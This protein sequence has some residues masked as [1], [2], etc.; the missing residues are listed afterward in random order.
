M[1]IRTFLLSLI[2]AMVTTAGF[3][4]KSNEGAYSCTAESSGGI[5]Y[6][7]QTKKWEGTRFRPLSKFVLRFN[8]VRTTAL[9]DEYAVSVSPEGK[10][11]PQSCTS[12]R[13]QFALFT[14]PGLLACRTEFYSYRFNLKSG[15]FV[16]A[17]MMGY[18]NDDDT[19]DDTPVVSGGRCTKMNE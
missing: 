10:N 5:F 1:L 8:Y 16:E 3:A 7:D 13:M 14:E 19:N 9:G 4:Q 6:N 15:R 2:A 18:V 12:H 11:D 17:Y